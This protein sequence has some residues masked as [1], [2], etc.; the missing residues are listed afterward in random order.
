MRGQAI[1]L[2]RSPTGRSLPCVIRLSGRFEERE[3]IGELLPRELFVEP[4]GISETVP[5][6]MSS[7]VLRGIRV[8]SRSPVASTTSSG[9]RREGRRRAPRPTSCARRPAR[10]RARSWRSERQS[11]PADRARCEPGRFASDPDRFFRRCSRWRGRTTHAAFGPLNTACPR[12]EIAALGPPRASSSRRRAWLRG[13]HVERRQQRLPLLLHGLRILRQARTQDVRPHARPALRLPE[14]RRPSR[15]QRLVAAVVERAQQARQLER[16]GGLEAIRPASSAAVRS[17]V[18]LFDGRARRRTGSTPAAP[19][20]GRSAAGRTHPASTLTSPPPWPASASRRTSIGR[21]SV[22][23]RRAAAP[24]AE[25]AAA[26]FGAG[27]ARTTETACRGDFGVARRPARATSGAI[28]R[29]RQHLHAGPCHDRHRAKRGQRARRRRRAVDGRGEQVLDRRVLAE[30]RELLLQIVAVRRA[31]ARRAAR[32]SWK[33]ARERAAPSGRWP[34]IHQAVSF[35]TGSA[36]S[37]SATTA[38]GFERAVVHL[39]ERDERGA[40]GTRRRR[41]AGPPP[42]DAGSSISISA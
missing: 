34:A 13:I 22:A 41:P 25:S 38:S 4:G 16:A 18:G 6:C 35:S 27:A 2:R 39:I 9:D 12:P 17:S 29:R 8:S 31:D 28:Q 1:G 21:A 37:S 3:Q 11:P 42:V 15:A 32:R 36:E 5:G 23:A 14:R 26:S 7:M 24:R 40:P 10:S 30:L 19:A 20:R 33:N